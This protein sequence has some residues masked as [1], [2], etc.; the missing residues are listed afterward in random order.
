MWC[1]YRFFRWLS[2]TFFL[3]NKTKMGGWPKRQISDR[4][5]RMGRR[6]FLI[7]S[8]KCP[9]S[10]F[11]LSIRP[12]LQ[13]N[14][15]TNEAQSRWNLVVFFALCR[16]Q[17]RTEKRRKSKADPQCQPFAWHEF[18]KSGANSLWNISLSH[19]YCWAHHSLLAGCLAKFSRTVSTFEPPWKKIVIIDDKP[20]QAW[21]LKIDC[22]DKLADW[23]TCRKNFSILFCSLG[24][25]I[26]FMSRVDKTPK[27]FQDK[28]RDDYR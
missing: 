11:L 18:Q 10:G 7:F 13:V 27:S 3:H 14:P 15:V 19:L 26:L 28:N 1:F 5:K 20:W 16:C 23:S 9:V 4:R 6:I 17:I 25:W 2:Q 12:L 8:Q 22:T 21:L 24:R